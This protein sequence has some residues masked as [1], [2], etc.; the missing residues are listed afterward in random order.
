[1]SILTIALEWPF[2]Y[3]IFKGQEDRKSRSIKASI[4]AQTASYAILIPLY[5]SCSG[6]TLVTKTTIDKSLSFLQTKNAWVYY[7]SEKGDALYKIRANGT[8]KQRIQDT[9]VVNDYSQLFVCNDNGKSVLKM[10]WH[11]REQNRFNDKLKVLIDNVPVA[12]ALETPFLMWSITKATVLPGDQ[13]IC[14]VGNQ[15]AA[16]DLNKSRIGLITFG[17][18]PVVILEK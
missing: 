17:S 16:V 2:C 15:I 12:T 7:L 18:S 9:G 8:E 10:S 5:L 11:E 3:W 14:Q 4:I 13:V 6:I 1:M